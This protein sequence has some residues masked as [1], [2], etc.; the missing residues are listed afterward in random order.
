MVDALRARRSFLASMSGGMTGIALSK[1][2]TADGHGGFGPT[3]DTPKAKQVLQIFCPGAASHIDL[4]DYK[5]A[6]EKFDGTP[7][8]GNT[9]VTFQGK[10]GNLM[11]SP[12]EFVSAGESGKRISSMMPNM[13]KHVDDMAFLHS[14]TSRTNTHGPGCIFMNS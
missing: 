12:W 8:P 6:L 13:A 7:L 3:T 4:W 9:E 1:I 14:M 11:K 2:A 5:P 10:N